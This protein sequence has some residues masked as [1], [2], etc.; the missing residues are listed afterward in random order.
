VTTPRRKSRAAT[1]AALAALVA[2]P[3][4]LASCEGGAKDTRQWGYRGTGREQV[5][6]RSQANAVLA[7]NVVPASLPPAPPGPAGAPWQNVQ[8]LNDVSVGEFNRTMIAMSQWVA[9]GAGNCS[10]CH[11]AGNLASDSLHTKR[12][13]RRM[14]QMTRD[15]NANYASHVQAT[16]VT[17]Y[18]CHLGKAQPNGYWFFSD[19]NQ[20]LRYYLDRPDARVQSRTVEP[21]AE[22]RSSIKQ[23][24]WTYAVMI[25]QSKGLGVNC[26]FCH[27]S[28][29]W[30]SWEQSGPK[31]V[32]ALYGSQM[33]RHVNSEYLAPLKPEYPASH[34]AFL[35]SRV[36]QVNRLGDAPKLQCITCH[37]GVSKPLYGAQMAR[38][39]PALWG[40]PAW[41]SAGRVLQ[42]EAVAGSDHAPSAVPAP[43]SAPAS[44]G[45]RASVKAVSE[46]KVV[47]ASAP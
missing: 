28:R 13:A 5:A 33:V 31:R 10:Y 22:N 42:F 25:A 1:R 46:D 11:V 23:T 9:G 40:T 24:E 12:V 15:I 6:D 32:I 34:L 47:A 38:D 37:N 29:A 36:G 45:A 41:D 18:T 7:S 8:V 3:L 4:V 44:G 14:L 16:G 21:T 19:E 26:T 39:Y 35:A 2:A 30:A 27:N 43:A 17:C 20:Y